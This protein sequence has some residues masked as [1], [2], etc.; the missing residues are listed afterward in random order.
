MEV[1]GCICMT[2]WNPDLF[3]LIL[4]ILGSTIAMFPC[5]AL[6]L[7]HSPAPKKIA[8]AEDLE[9]ENFYL[10]FFFI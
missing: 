1:M 4:S 9:P 7:P 3:W 2:I 5:P 10:G 8:K 6:S